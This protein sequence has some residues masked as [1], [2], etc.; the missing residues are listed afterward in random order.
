MRLR[1]ES[2]LPSRDRLYHSFENP[3]LFVF[4]STKNF[5]MRK[6]SFSI[7]KHKHIQDNGESSKSMSHC[8]SININS[9]VR[10]HIQILTVGS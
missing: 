1:E 4:L 6:I 7:G 10:R 2:V 5:K 9:K 3:N 8:I